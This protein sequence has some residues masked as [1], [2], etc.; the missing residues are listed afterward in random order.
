[1]RDGISWQDM[2]VVRD[3][4]GKPSLM[5]SGR[6]EAICNERGIHV[7][8]LSYSHDG[9]YATATVLLETP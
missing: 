7:I 6:A 4:L 3:P 5:L 1:M 8:H 2:N 9:D